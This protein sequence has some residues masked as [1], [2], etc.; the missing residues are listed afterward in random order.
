M[1]ASKALR[2]KG[3]CSSCPAATDCRAAATLAPSLFH[4]AAYQRPRAPD[5]LDLAL[6]EVI[7]RFLATLAAPKL[8][9]WA[10][11]RGIGICLSALFDLC[12][13]GLYSTQ[14]VSHLGEFTQ[15][16]LACGKRTAVFPYTWM[17]PICV[18]QGRDLASCYLP[19]ARREDSRDF[20]VQDR[21]AKDYRAFVHF[22]TNGVIRAQQD[23]AVSPPTSQW[24]PGQAISDGQAGAGGAKI[25][26]TKFD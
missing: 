7:E 20:P 12:M 13:T 6:D 2:L 10:Q 18:E 5:E 17:C 16:A 4:T 14:L 11:D 15:E 21:L 1:T 9:G 3:P 26:A 25:A 24:Q 22:C 19:G 8:S 23:H